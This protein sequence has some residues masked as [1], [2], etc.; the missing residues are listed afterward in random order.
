MYVLQLTSGVGF[1]WLFFLF[2]PAHVETFKYSRMYL[3]IP[4]VAGQSNKKKS[5]WFVLV[6]YDVW[7]NFNLAGCFFSF[8][9]KHK[10]HQYYFLSGR[11]VE[12]SA[13]SQLVTSHEAKTGAA[14]LPIPASQIRG[15]ISLDPASYSKGQ[16]CLLHKCLHLREEGQ[17]N[18]P[19]IN[20][21]SLLEEKETAAAHLDV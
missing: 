16:T 5:V 15:H 21:L 11:L 19:E 1:V 10:K 3:T 2:C 8:F 18:Y 14:D 17:K 7:P 20:L 9:L 13:V 4:Q 12:V 6:L